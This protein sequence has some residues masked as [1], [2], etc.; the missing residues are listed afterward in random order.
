MTRY[1]PKEKKTE[2]N[3]MIDLQVTGQTNIIVE[4]NSSV[5]KLLA[6]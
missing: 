1:L 2:Q 5:E 3:I 6:N 4:K